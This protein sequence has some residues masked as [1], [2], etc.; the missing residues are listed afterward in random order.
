MSPVLIY[1]PFDTLALELDTQIPLDG[2]RLGL[3][4]GVAAPVLA[5]RT[6]SG[7]T[8]RGSLLQAPP[9]DR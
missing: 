1:G 5:S 3:A 4:A 7:N 6:A 2:E 9:L 8:N